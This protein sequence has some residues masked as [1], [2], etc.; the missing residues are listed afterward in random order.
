MT[1]WQAKWRGRACLALSAGMAAWFF[2]LAEAKAAPIPC[3]D[4]PLAQHFVDG[5]KP[6]PNT[7]A[8]QKHLDA[9]KHATTEAGCDKELRQVDYYA[10]R[11]AEADKRA[12]AKAQSAA[13]QNQAPKTQ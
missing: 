11:S 2:L 13:P 5:L 1:Q 7:R 8:A 3:S 12:A 6:G 9:A 10:R 4:I